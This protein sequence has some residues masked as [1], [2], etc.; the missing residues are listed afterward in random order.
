[1]KTVLKEVI[2]MKMIEI[3]EEDHKKFKESAKKRGI[4]LRAYMHLLA[5]KEG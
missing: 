5:K 4:T 3:Y 2:S 1:M